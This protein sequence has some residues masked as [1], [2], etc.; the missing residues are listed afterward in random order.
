MSKPKSPNIS[1]DL[2][3]RVGG[4]V[5]QTSGH[6]LL[7]RFCTDVENGITPSA[8]DLRDIAAALRVALSGG[9]MSNSMDEVGRRLGLAKKQGKKVSEQRR[10]HE[11][12]SRIMQYMLDVHQRIESGVQPVTAERAVRAEYA[13][14]FGIGDRAMRDMVNKYKEGAVLALRAVYGIEPPDLWK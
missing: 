4:F 13:E 11:M 6:K 2:L 9:N 12:T 1:I 7:Y 8:D 14:R 3:S 10:W 5:G